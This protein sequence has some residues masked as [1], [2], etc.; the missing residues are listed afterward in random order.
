MTVFGLFFR[1][2]VLRILGRPIMARLLLMLLVVEAIFLAES[3]TSL[4]EQALRHGGLAADIFVLLLFKAPEILDLALA[5]G[6]LIAVYF[7]TGDARNRGEL[8][9]LATAGVHWFRVIALVM[10]LGLLGGG[11]SM[12]NAGF[13][14]PISNFAERLKMADLRKNHVVSRMRD[15][16]PQNTLL[17]IRDTTF[18]ATPPHDSSAPID[19]TDFSAPSDGQTPAS[20]RGQLFVFQPDVDGNWRASQSSNWRIDE[21]NSPDQQADDQT[22]NTHIPGGR[23]SHS[24]LLDDLS[25]YQGPYPQPDPQSRPL[26]VNRFSVA[27]AQFDFRMSDAAPP[28]D[29]ARTRTERLLNLS[30]EETPRLARLATRA[31]MVPMGG[32]LALA[33]LLAGA[34]AGGRARYVALPVAALIM[35]MGD[36]LVRSLISGW[37]GTL[38]PPLLIALAMVIY[39]GPVLAYLVYRGEALMKPAGRDT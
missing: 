3:F 16:G 12:L 26:F 18:L 29:R 7:A 4:M 13:L 32:L 21:T 31:L 6:M 37:V 11:L 5:T 25:V 15:P 28:V 38:W 30:A 9:I 2:P 8:V 10:S 19:S 22:T 27:T 34:A 36:V 1:L 23:K 33:A 20:Q 17:T 39:L 24:I 35:M 14:L